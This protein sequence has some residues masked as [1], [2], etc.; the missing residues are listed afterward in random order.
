MENAPSVLQNTTSSSFLSWKGKSSLLTMGWKPENRT[1]FLEQE[2]REAE[3]RGK[4]LLLWGRWRDPLSKFQR[5][6]ETGLLQGLFSVHTSGRLKCCLFVGSISLLE[7]LGCKFVLLYQHR[8]VKGRIK[9]SVR[10]RSLRTINW[11]NYMWYHT[12]VG[13]NQMK[14]LWAG[15]LYWRCVSGLWLLLCC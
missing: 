9:S 3:F 14:N 6:Q 2:K 13:P 11:R 8:A 12:E 4:L 5:E 7:Q 15:F 1:S 10:K